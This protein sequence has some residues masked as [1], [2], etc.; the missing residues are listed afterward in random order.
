VGPKHTELFA[1]AFK[2]LLGHP[3][4]GAVAFVCCLSSD[5]VDALADS[6]IFKIPGW[7]ISAVID[8][9]GDRRI[10]ADQA[11]EQREN[12]GDAALLLIDPRRA[13]AGLDGIYSAGHEINETALFKEAQT[14]ARKLLRGQIKVI[15]RS[16][17][18][19]TMSDAV[20]GF[21]ERAISPGATP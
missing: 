15:D 11:V 5:Q 13:G 7:S 12:R 4:K 20:A 19:G 21:F 1:E 3:T 9:P 16:L 6:S 8:V 18:V 10:T 17:L 14:L 2:K